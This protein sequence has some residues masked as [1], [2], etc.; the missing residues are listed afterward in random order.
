M[1]AAAAR[2][3][4][5]RVLDQMMSHA[6]TITLE[7]PGDLTTMPRMTLILADTGTDFDNSYVISSVER[8]ISFQHGFTQTVQARSPY[9]TTS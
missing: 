3:L 8:R 6:R 9:W 2:V 1:N 5:A 7:M 4:A